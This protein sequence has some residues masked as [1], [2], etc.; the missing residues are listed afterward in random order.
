MFQFFEIGHIL[1]LNSKFYCEQ[2]KK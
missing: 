1:V 2:N